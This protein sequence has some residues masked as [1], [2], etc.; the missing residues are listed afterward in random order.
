[1]IILHTPQ[2]KREIYLQENCIEYFSRIPKDDY[3]NIFK[4][5]VTRIVTKSRRGFHVFETPQEIVQLIEKAKNNAIYKILK[6]GDGN[7]ENPKPTRSVP[8]HDNGSLHAA[9]APLHEQ[10]QEETEI[11]FKHFETIWGDVKLIKIHC[12][13]GSVTVSV[14]IIDHKDTLCTN[15]PSIS[16]LYVKEEH[17]G[18]G[19]GTKLLEEAEETLR[20]LNHTAV[21]VD[22][23][24][25]V[26]EPWVKEW[27]IRKGYKIY[28]RPSNEDSDAPTL[29][30]KYPL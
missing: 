12:N 15:A 20:Q 19:I 9:Q 5:D 27:F 23:D 11:I 10:Q 6:R 28:A 30:E 2:K 8:L 24:P 22:Y 7:T 25:T 26:S 29:F 4:E 3:N 17:R 1:M 13:Y 18:K 16:A 21:H 14:Q